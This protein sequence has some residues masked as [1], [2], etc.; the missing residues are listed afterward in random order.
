[1]TY[2]DKEKMKL[3]RYGEESFKIIDSS[4][5]N[6]EVPNGWRQ[7]SNVSKGRVLF[8]NHQDFQ[9]Q[10]DS[11]T[12]ADGDG[13]MEYLQYYSEA[14]HVRM[15]HI[16]NTVDCGFANVLLTKRYFNGGGKVKEQYTFWADYE[17]RYFRYDFPS[18]KDFKKKHLRRMDYSMSLLQTNDRSKMLIRVSAFGRH[19]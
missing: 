15:K 12:V 9:F 10:N 7:C 13:I 11:L 18:P 8:K 19:G 5:G 17:N 16:K 6:T 2:M 1:M 3:Q 14:I 4:D